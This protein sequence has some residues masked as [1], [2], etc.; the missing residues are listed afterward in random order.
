C[1]C[2]TGGGRRGGTPWA[3]LTLLGLGAVRRRRR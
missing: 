2:T 3:L 1:N